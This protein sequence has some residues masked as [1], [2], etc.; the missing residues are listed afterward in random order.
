M[1]HWQGLT[2]LTGASYTPLGLVNADPAGV[3]VR[4]RAVQ[5]SG[6]S[7]CCDQ[8]Q[9]GQ[10]QGVRHRP[11]RHLASGDRG[12]AERPQ[13]RSRLG[14]VGAFQRRRARPAGHGR[15]RRGDRAL[16]AARSAIAHRRRKGEEPCH[17][18][19]APGR[20]CTPMCRPLKQRTGSDWTMAAWRGMVAPKGHP[21]RGARPACGGDQEGLRQ[22]GVQGLH[23]QP[24]FRRD[25]PAAG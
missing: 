10:V 17:H 16:L 15:G 25:L 6:R 24:R 23:E 2:E 7:A 4:R 1:M 8:S 12:H 18:G 13:N 21:G 11:G 14:A 3:Q 9:P 5:E 19:P 22:Q 20:R